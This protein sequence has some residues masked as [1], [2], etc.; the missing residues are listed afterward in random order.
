MYKIGGGDGGL[1]VIVVIHGESWLWGSSSL[2]DGRV[3]AALGQVLVVTFN[4]RLG[5]LGE[6]LVG[7]S[8]KINW[9]RIGRSK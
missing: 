7:G 9:T 1:S 3:L 6:F 8:I 2:Y 4:F 5:I